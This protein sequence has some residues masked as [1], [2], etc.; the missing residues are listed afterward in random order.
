M[1]TETEINYLIASTVTATLETM[2]ALIEKGVPPREAA[3]LMA[4]E[5]AKAI[6]EPTTVTSR[7]LN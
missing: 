7:E 6:A 1:M 4:D 3:Q 2:V 5:A